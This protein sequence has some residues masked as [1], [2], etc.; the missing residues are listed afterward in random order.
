MAGL[1]N[2]A[3]AGGGGASQIFYSNHGSFPTT[4][5]PDATAIWSKNGSNSLLK[6]QSNNKP[7]SRT[8]LGRK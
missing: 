5:D 8:Y 3:R 4:A 7:V 2:N 6:H 1:I